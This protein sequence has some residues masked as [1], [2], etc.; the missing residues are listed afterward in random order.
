MRGVPNER[1]PQKGFSNGSF[2]IGLFPM[3]FS[4]VDFSAMEIFTL[5]SVDFFGFTGGNLIEK[6]PLGKS[7]LEKIYWGR[8][9]LRKPD[10]EN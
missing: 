2:P 5:K 10:W 8:L 7:P 9:H 1:F 3:D 4:Q 6:T